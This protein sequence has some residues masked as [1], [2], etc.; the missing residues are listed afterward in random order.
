MRDIGILS[1]PAKDSC[2]TPCGFSQYESDRLLCPPDVEDIHEDFHRLTRDGVPRTAPANNSTLFVMPLVL[3]IR[4][5]KGDGNNQSTSGATT[6][7]LPPY[8]IKTRHQILNLYMCQ[9]P[10]PM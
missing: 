2:R 8:N 6:T 9:V 7:C 10:M 5:C 3:Q 1:T 4:V